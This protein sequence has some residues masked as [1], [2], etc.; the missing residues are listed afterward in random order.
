MSTDTAVPDTTYLTSS[1]SNTE[2]SSRRRHRHRHSFS[3]VTS[4]RTRTL[5]RR[6]LEVQDLV[7]S[8]QRQRTDPLNIESDTDCVHS[9][10]VFSHHSPGIGALNRVSVRVFDDSRNWNNSCARWLLDWSWSSWIKMIFTIIFLIQGI[11]TV[12]WLVLFIRSYFPS[13]DVVQWQP[14]SDC[15]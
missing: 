3:C 7:Q 13:T 4:P 6:R 9:V 5:L 11:A 2:F 8:R 14:Q 15:G 10:Y 1:L 12:L